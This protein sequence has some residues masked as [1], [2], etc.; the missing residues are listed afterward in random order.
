MSALN[1]LMMGFAAALTLK[2]LAMCFLGVLMGQM[3]GVLP[4]IGPISAT[5]LALALIALT[6][7]LLF[8]KRPISS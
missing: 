7:P 5:L 1:D 2:H 6:A 3:V 8:R 4:G